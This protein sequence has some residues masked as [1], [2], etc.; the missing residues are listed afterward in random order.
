MARLGDANMSA[1]VDESDARAR[2]VACMAG[3]DA[4]GA[5]VRA[6]AAAGVSAAAREAAAGAEVAG[7]RRRVSQLAAEVRCTA[8]ALGDVCARQ[9]R[10]VMCAHG[11]SV[12]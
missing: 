3:E 9:Q 2:E 11:S 10:W 4:S 6:A 1:L 5:A 7:L 12:G 8:A